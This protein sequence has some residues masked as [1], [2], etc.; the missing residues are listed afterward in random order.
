[1]YVCM[2]VYIYIYIMQTRVFTCMSVAVFGPRY[3]NSVARNRHA[4]F[5]GKAALRGFFFF[6]PKPHVRCEVRD[7]IMTLN[8]TYA[9]RFAT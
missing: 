4:V 8:R 3:P 5:F 9:A 7:M 6:F 1:M 2:Y